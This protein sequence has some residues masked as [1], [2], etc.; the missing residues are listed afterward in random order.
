MKIGPNSIQ[1][2]DISKTR[3]FFLATPHVTTQREPKHV[4]E[5]VTEPR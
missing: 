4:I 3:N 1:N 2:P 5:K